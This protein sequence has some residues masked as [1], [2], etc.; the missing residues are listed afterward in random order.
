M[1]GI[2]H[3]PR[4]APSRQRHPWTAVGTRR[5]L[6]G[7]GCEKSN[8][9]LPVRRGI[10]SA[11]FSLGVLQGL[12]Q[13]GLLARFDY[14]STVS[15]GGYIGGWLS[16][17]LH[18]RK[19]DV[20][21]VQAALAARESPP[22]LRNLR[23]YTNYLTPNPG[24][25]SRDTWAA[26]MLWVRNLLLN[27][28]I[29]VPALFAAALLPILYA[30]LIEE[31]GVVFSWPLLIVALLCLGVGVFNGAR[32]MPSHSYSEDGA[33][34]VTILCPCSWS[35]RCWFGRS[36]CHWWRR[37]GCGRRCRWARSSATSFP[38]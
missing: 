11:A 7:G 32:H 36:W 6:Q 17:L 15:G 26:I 33:E 27:W 28:F 18:A 4:R 22:E 16:M 8:G 35:C 10:R 37:P 23:S 3:D 24:I 34:A 20:A 13:N 30:G 29:F 5:V 1:G 19:G 14:L 9:A 38:G 21:A 31:I 12:A 25:A 2:F